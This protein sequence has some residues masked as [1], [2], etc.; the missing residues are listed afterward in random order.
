ML[1]A[2]D[3]ELGFER[4]L[5]RLAGEASVR[6]EFDASRGEF[7]AHPAARLLPGAER[8]HLE[9]FLLERPSA[10]LGGVPVQTWRESLAETSAELLTGFA[11]SLAGAFEV[12]SLVPGEGLWVRDLFTLGEHP[13]VEARASLAIEVGDLV[14]GRLFPAGGAAFLL[15]QAASVFRDPDLL[16]AVRTDL[17]AMRAARRGVLRVQ[18]LELEHLFHGPG[19]L[20]TV[21]PSAEEAFER[22]R[23][24]LGALEL[25]P[26]QVER[27]LAAV[28]VAVPARDGRVV[29]EAL[30]QLAFDTDADLVA[31]RLALAEL[32]SSV[33]TGAPRA[34]EPAGG[35]EPAADEDDDN[36][37]VQAALE[38]FDRG[39]AEGKDLELL[40]RELER[41]LGVADEP[42]TEPETEADEAP[43][44]PDFP[45]VVG[46]MVEEFLWEI[47]HEQGAAE[48]RVLEPLR[49]LGTYGHQIGVFE[50]LTPAQLLDFS[51]RWLLDEGRVTNPRELIGVLDA[52]AVFCRWSEE[53]QG[54]PLWKP[55]ESTL[56]A[57]RESLPR[58][59]LLRR[60]LRA[61]AGEGA[62]R[63]LRVGGTGA[64][65]RALDGL[66]RELVLV[67]EQA[68][69][70]RVGELV[71]VAR[72]E[73]AFVLGASY[74]AEI[75][76][77]L[78]E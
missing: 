33:A 10:A 46:A 26:A 77:L 40:F 49:E 50:E 11:H 8:R 35:A 58:H 32:W 5:A 41:E 61:G 14:V 47:G 9:W 15:S 60:S 71:R 53:R 59:V 29:T 31:A 37:T 7:F 64:V 42:E 69:N 73:G 44:A 70:L 43:G 20:P 13:I 67:P 55:F 25:T 39:R 23:T 38:A 62:F 21:G 1:S 76:E 75:A 78:P 52:L 4:F 48:A 12:T 65:V 68:H 72:H 24:A 6:R 57:L 56:A 30:N 3:L 36:A 45:G 63:V 54:V 16:A 17:Q 27:A 51:A 34:P 2:Q 22:A 66:E 74:P 18:Q 19:S 28:R